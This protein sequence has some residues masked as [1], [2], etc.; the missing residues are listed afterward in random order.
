MNATCK[1]GLARGAGLVWAAVIGAVELPAQETTA[2]AVRG[3]AAQSS[4]DTLLPKWSIS[5]GTDFRNLSIGRG[6]GVEVIFLAAFR[7]SGSCRCPS[8]L[9]VAS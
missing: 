8:W 4:L 3:K 5:P 9:F 6:S 7:G 2:I 1:W